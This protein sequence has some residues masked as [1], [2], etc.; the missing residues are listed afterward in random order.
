MFVCCSDLQGVLVLGQAQKRSG[1]SS[2]GF[3]CC[4][5]VPPRHTDGAGGRERMRGALEGDSTE[6]TER[7]KSPLGPARGILGGTGSAT[8]ATSPS[9]VAAVTGGMGTAYWE[10]AGRGSSGR[11]SQAGAAAGEWPL[12]SPQQRSSQL[13]GDEGSLR[14]LMRG[15]ADEERP[16][17]P[18]ARG[19][20]RVVGV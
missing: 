4:R 16:A 14:I 9:L 8:G 5:R 20:G 11:S 2:D 17:G 19:G 13:C 12:D 18:K 10:E 6:L 7:R 3:V 1:F 15:V